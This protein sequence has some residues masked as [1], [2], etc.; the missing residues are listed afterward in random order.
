MDGAHRE[1]RTGD[2]DAV[3]PDAV[4]AALADDAG[5]VD[6]PGDL[7]RVGGTRVT[8]TVPADA[9]SL[10]TVDLGEWTDLPASTIPF[11]PAPVRA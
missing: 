9:E 1:G 10:T 11:T 6:L 2:A 3:V 8:T 5:R 7:R 4:A